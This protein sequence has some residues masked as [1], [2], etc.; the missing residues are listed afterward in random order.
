MGIIQ[1]L[2]LVK[3]EII[4]HLPQRPMPAFGT[5][6]T[7]R[8]D[9]DLYSLADTNQP[10]IPAFQIISDRYYRCESPATFPVRG[11]LS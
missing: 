6:R 2:V 7:V 5:E 9:S 1:R 3:E 8:L 10:H 4:R 11:V